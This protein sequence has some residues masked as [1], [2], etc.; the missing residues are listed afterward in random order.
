MFFR[1]GGG[2]CPCHLYCYCDMNGVKIVNSAIIGMDFKVVVVAG[3]SYVIK[4]PTIHRIAGAGYYLADIEGTNIK[5][6]I[7]SLNSIE[8]ATKALSYFICGDESLDEELGAGTLQEINEAL[9]TAYSLIS[10]ENFTRL[11][12][13]AR[14]VANL[15]AKS[16]Q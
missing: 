9:E 12:G 4:P 1:C 7:S 10:V 16:K 3:R 14:N 6:I 15:T 5:D 2:D 8:N 11:L 13:L